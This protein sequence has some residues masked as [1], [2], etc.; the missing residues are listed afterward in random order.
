MGELEIILLAEVGWV[1]GGGGGTR[2]RTHS[3]CWMRTCT[4]ERY[5]HL[6]ACL[7]NSVHKIRGLKH[8]SSRTERKVG[9][10][11]QCWGNFFWWSEASFLAFSVVTFC[12]LLQQQTTWPTSGSCSL[13]HAHRFAECC[14]RLSTNVLHCWPRTQPVEDFNEV[15]NI[16]LGNHLGL[17]KNF[18]SHNLD[19]WTLQLQAWLC[20]L[21]LCLNVNQ[22]S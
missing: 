7:H 4:G 21:G 8:S 16:L 15:I 14:W 2:G 18:K 1:R 3:G 13:M 20:Y 22:I 19:L 11:V 17:E 10:G 12:S 9:W 6:L 5:P